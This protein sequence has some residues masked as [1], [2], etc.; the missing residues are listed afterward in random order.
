METRLNMS[1]DDIDKLRVI[2]NVLEGRLTWLAAAEALDIS[3]R[4]IGRL[5]A[6]VRSRGNRGI[7]H[8]LIGRNSNNQGDPEL[9]GMALSELHN[10]RWQGFT[11]V[12]GQQKLE[13]LHGIILSDTT[14]RKLMTMTGLWQRHRP[15]AKHRAWRERRACVGM[16]IQLD[17]SDH[18]WFEGRGPKCALLVYIDDATSRIL[19][20]EFVKVEDTL[21]LMRS[22]GVYLGKHGRPVAYYVD[23]DSIYKINRQT[24]I[25]EEL[26]D[27]DPITQFTRAMTELGIEV[28]FANSPQA[29]GRVER[30]FDTHQDRLVKELRLANINDMDAGNIFLRTVYIDDHNTRFAVDP[31]SNTNAHRPLLEGHRLDQILSRRTE[32]SVANDY[33]LRFQHQFFQLFEEQPVR[34]RPKDKVEVEIR[35]DGTTHLRAKG[36]YLRFKPIEKRPYR[37]HLA[38]R[39]SSGKIYDD[40]RLKGRGSKPAPD[41]PWRRL[42]LSGPQRVSL[43]PSVVSK[44]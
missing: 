11:A 35:L 19:H 23:K 6:Q 39:P 25:D 9:L 43:A 44:L 36:S 4:Q 31:A 27:E 2:R 10:P 42:F 26:R 29:K 15:K 37:P 38:M 32:R 24:T 8:G 13:S 30:S 33:T 1:G 5:C 14:V 3:E 7:L 17:G 21:N 12:F 41:H 34:V 28:I 20:A 22:T 18:D 40:P 16:L